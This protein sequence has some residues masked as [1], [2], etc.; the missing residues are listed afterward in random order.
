MK[1][2]F[3]LHDQHMHS[4]FSNDSKQT[5]KEYLDEAV[6]RDCKYF[7]LTDHLDLNI[8]NSGV[9]WRADYKGEKE[10]LD[11]V[12]E[13]YPTLTLLMGIEVGYK[14]DYLEENQKEIDAIDFDLIN[15]SVH[16]YL[17][18]DFYFYTNYEKH[19]IENTMN[20][21]FSKE[22]EGMNMMKDFDV[23][24]HIDYAYKTLLENQNNRKISEWEDWLKKIFVLLVKKDKCLEINTKVQETIRKINGND[25]HINYLLSLY[26]ECGGK[27]LTLS[28][29]AHSV[30]RFMADFDYYKNIIK[31]NGFDHLCFFVKRKRYE[32]D[33]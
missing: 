17:D 26:K 21:Y 2:F 29:D 9:D 10:Y 12:K 1:Y 3:T 18:L 30:D 14:I 7:I 33:I 15:L 32:Y 27:H 5:I 11:S 24:S 19:G 13:D 16:D 20:Y 25:S 4:L 6:K 23:L 28:S 22:I 8:N 31:Q